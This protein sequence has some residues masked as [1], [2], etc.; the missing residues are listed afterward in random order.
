VPS[1]VRAGQSLLGPAALL[2]G[3]AQALAGTEERITLGGRDDLPEL[4]Q[5]PDIA[6]LHFRGTW[7]IFSPEFEAPR[8][9]QLAQLQTWSA[10]P[11]G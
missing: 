9:I 1:A 4:A 11:A 8:T 7:G 2:R 5:R 10:R 6:G 3:I